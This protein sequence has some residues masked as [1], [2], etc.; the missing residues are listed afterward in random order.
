MLK[1]A[2]RSTPDF[3][4]HLGLDPGRSFEVHA[5]RR[6]MRS[7][8]EGRVAPQIVLA[9]TQSRTVKA[10][11][12]AGV[13]EHQFR[14]GSTVIIDLSPTPRVRYRIVKNVNSD[15]RPKRTA[16]FLGRV[17]ADPLWTMALGLDGGERFAALHGLGE[18]TSSPSTGK[19]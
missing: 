5:L 3:A 1:S 6:A 2:F 11:P 19:R 16:A 4:R 17:A 7:S 18:G 15:T 8:P 12:E 9:L 14:G 13:P 10:D